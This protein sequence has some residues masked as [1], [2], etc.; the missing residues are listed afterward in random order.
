MDIDLFNEVFLILFSHLIIDN[1]L[2][3]STII[4]ALIPLVLPLL[5][6][7]SIRYLLRMLSLVR[8]KIHLFCLCIDFV[9]GNQLP[10]YLP[11]VFFVCHAFKEQACS[12]QL[13]VSLVVVPTED[14][15]GVFWLEHVSDWRVIKNDDVFHASS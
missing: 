14:W 11:H 2:M 5:L 12:L 7:P 9:V 10:D 3:L 13:S 8:M 4:S 1:S 15:H 6:M